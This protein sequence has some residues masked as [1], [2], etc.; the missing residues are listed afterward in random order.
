MAEHSFYL[1]SVGAQ[2]YASQVSQFRGKYFFWLRLSSIKAN[3]LSAALMC[4]KL[5][6][7]AL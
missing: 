6:K 1:A 5:Y 2:R 7:N 4:V 3:M